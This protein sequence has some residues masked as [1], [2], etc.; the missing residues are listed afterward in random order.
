VASPACDDFKETKMTMNVTDRFARQWLRKDNA[1]R[2]WAEG[3]GFDRP[4]FFVPDGEC[5]NE[6]SHATLSILEL[7]D[8]DT[9]TAEKIDLR[10]IANA[11]SEF[12]SWR[13]EYGPG[14]DPGEDSWK[15]LIQSSSEI[16][17]PT[18]VHTW[19]LAQAGNGKVTLRLRMEN[20][21][22]GYAERVLHLK[23]EYSPPTATPTET[24]PPTAIPVATDT[25]V[26]PTSTS[27][28]T[29]T[30]APSDTPVPTDTP[31]PSETP[32]P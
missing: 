20:R 6:S 5:K 12:D 11:T 31:I 21:E 7:K 23:I 29:D 19:N 8:G 2:A 28:P 26:P 14:D 17:D 1:G 27:A 10:I 9:L 30:T 24:P 18:N 4:I 32:T 25:P 22:G 3:M 16:K 13:L 15:I